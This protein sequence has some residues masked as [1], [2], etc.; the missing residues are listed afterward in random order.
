MSV[1]VVGPLGMV[2]LFLSTLAMMMGIGALIGGG[3]PGVGILFFSL[4]G[5]SCWF[6]YSLV[7]SLWLHRR[8]ASK[9]IGLIFGLI[10]LSVFV[11]NTADST[12]ARIGSNRGWVA[13]NYIDTFGFGIIFLNGWILTA[14]LLFRAAYPK[15]ATAAPYHG[16]PPAFRKLV[17]RQPEPSASH[18]VKPKPCHHRMATRSTSSQD[19]GHE[20]EML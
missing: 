14:F 20:N 19:L 11:V 10:V 2:T 4:G 16:D 13:R 3:N 5:L 9:V 15:R 1:L 8:E 6:L 7:V 12:I 18:K 17:P